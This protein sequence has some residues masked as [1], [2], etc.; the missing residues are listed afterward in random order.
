MDYTLDNRIY[1]VLSIIALENRWQIEEVFP[2]MM[3]CPQKHLCYFSFLI[4]NNNFNKNKSFLSKIMTKSSENAKQLSNQQ[5][6]KYLNSELRK[7]KL[8][9]PITIE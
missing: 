9:L 8:A 2:S 3:V 6:A 5:F 1:L 4:I 7:T